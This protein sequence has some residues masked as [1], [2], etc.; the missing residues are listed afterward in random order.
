MST[1]VLIHGAFHGGWCF[2]RLAPLLRQSGHDVIAPDLT[3]A[4]RSST[5]VLD[6]LS[7]A[8]I[9]VGHSSGG[10]V[11]SELARRY[12]G[13]CGALVYLTAFLLP[14]GHTPHDLGPDPRSR[15]PE[16]VV[17]D[18]A[19]G[20]TRVNPDRAAAVFYHD[21]DPDDAARALARLVPEPTRTG[22][23][24][25]PPPEETTVRRFYVECTRDR[26]LTIERQRQMYTAMPCE[27]VYTMHTG[28]SPFLADP[29]ALA[30]HLIDIAGSISGPPYGTH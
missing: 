24:S 23:A 11:I 14:P 16:A 12:P 21:C 26:A 22:P 1:F 20:Q 17:R 7:Q 15:F 28:H 6:R 25:S 2:E 29:R 3:G 9:L 5:D 19:P 10:M 8:A 18:A 27:K 4:A 13:R 30:D